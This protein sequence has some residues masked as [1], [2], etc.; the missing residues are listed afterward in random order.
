MRAAPLCPAMLPQQAEEP[1]SAFS[2]APAKM[3]SATKPPAPASLA[4]L[5]PGT[6]VEG[7]CGVDAS[8]P[9]AWLDRAKYARGLAAYREN[10]FAIGLTFHFSLV[11]GFNVRALVH[12][13]EDSGGS[14][15]PPQALNRYLDT[16]KHMARRRHPR[17]IRKAQE[18]HTA[19]RSSST[20]ISSQSRRWRS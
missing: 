16:G 19:R 6:H 3:P 11:L 8:V 9:P 12:I 7:D 5:L 17:G 4:D 20:S 2:G 15:T 14:G 18:A 10:S 13:L 1:P